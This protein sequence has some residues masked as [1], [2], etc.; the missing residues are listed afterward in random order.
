MLLRQHQRGP[1]KLARTCARSI[2]HTLLTLVPARHHSK[3]NSACKPYSWRVRRATRWLEERLFESDIEFEQ[4]C[5][6]LKIST[7]ATQPL[8]KETAYTPQEY[9]TKKRM[10]A[11]CQLLK[12]SNQ[13]IT[14]IAVTLGHSSS[15][16]F[17]TVFKTYFGLTPSEY[18]KR[19]RTQQRPHAI[20]VSSSC[21]CS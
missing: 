3:R 7:R 12:Q 9:V 14:A 18:R 20:G 1:H 16:Y 21:R 13:S 19:N 4:L 17:A 2:V 5:E 6:S 15:Q 10:E 11:A 8:Q